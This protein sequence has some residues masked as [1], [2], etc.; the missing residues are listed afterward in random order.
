MNEEQLKKILSQKLT[1]LL[2][3]LQ[4]QVVDMGDIMKAQAERVLSETLEEFKKYE[5][6]KSIPKVEDK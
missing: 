6:M 3:R 4:M 5:E 1:N 2:Q